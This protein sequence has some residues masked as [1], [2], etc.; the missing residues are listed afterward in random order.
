ML[1]F[2]AVAVP[3]GAYVLVSVISV[4]C[5]LGL[6]LRDL[7]TATLPIR[8]APASGTPAGGNTARGKGGRRGAESTTSQRQ[9]QAGAGAGTGAA[10]AGASP[11]AAL[12]GLLASPSKAP[13]TVSLTTLSAARNE[14]AQ[15]GLR[16]LRRFTMLTILLIIVGGS[17][18]GLASWSVRVF[19][20]LFSMSRGC[21][22]SVSPNKT[23]PFA[24]S[25]L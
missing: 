15:R 18:M 22:R 21:V 2:I 14:P 20:C 8:V 16:R 5:R 1:M 13:S 4:N 9:L 23:F 11:T 12:G 25:G 17:L 6:S 7:L 24:G 3:L 10:A 19:A